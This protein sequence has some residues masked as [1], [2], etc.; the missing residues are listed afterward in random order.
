[1]EDFNSNKIKYLFNEQ[2]VLANKPRK[3][4]LK[5]AQTSKPLMER[6]KESAAQEANKLGSDLGMGI[7]NPMKYIKSLTQLSKDEEAIRRAQGKVKTLTAEEKRLRRNEIGTNIGT[8]ILAAGSGLGSGYLINRA[9][10]NKEKPKE[11]KKSNK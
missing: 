9:L 3:P 2:E 8:G 4:S 11:K 1:M 10:S 6:F 5:G 7:F